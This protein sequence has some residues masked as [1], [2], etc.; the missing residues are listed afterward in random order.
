M[1]VTIIIILIAIL[2]FFFIAEFFGRRKHIG[3]WWSFALLLCGF[4]PGIIAIFSS[5]SASKQPTL[6]GNSYK[7]GGYVCLFFSGLNLLALIS[8]SG[9]LG[10]LFPVFL[11]LGI[12]LIQLSQGLIINKM[13]KY[14]FENINLRNKS[15]ENKNID[16]GYKITSI[17]LENLKELKEKGLLSEEEYTSKINQIKEILNQNRV[18]ETVEYKQLKDLFD[19]GILTKV[20]FEHKIEL[21]KKD[22]RIDNEALNVEEFKN[23]M[24][25]TLV[26]V[27]S[28]YFENINKKITPSKKLDF[29][30]IIILSVFLISILVYFVVTNKSNINDS[31]DIETFVDSTVVLGN[32]YY[33]SNLKPIYIKKFVYVSIEIQ[34]PELKVL[35]IPSYY[36]ANGF[37]QT[38]EPDYFI[39]YIEETHTTDI[40]EIQD[41]NIDEEYKIMDNAREQLSYQLN[42]Y[43]HIYSTN[44]LI[45]CKDEI[46]RERLS[47]EKSK[48]ID[49][50][51]FTFDSYAEA[52]QHKQSLKIN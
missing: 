43:N 18:F 49:T 45:K 3:R 48:I 27:N 52:S 12:Y 25:D 26:T 41:Y 33:E 14:Y 29:N 13:P 1:A 32:D 47:K 9:K 44:L 20:E 4:I 11:V 15:F 17:S 6:G 42:T 46:E 19:N 35:Q 39:D 16:G 50:Q 34:K 38:Y 7:I 24:I 8:T 40:F 10:Q 51:I 31:N 30:I 37:Y 23:E 28:N 36:D 2:I 22:N 21:L 5:P